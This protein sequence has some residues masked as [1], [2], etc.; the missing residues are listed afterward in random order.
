MSSSSSDSDVAPVRTSRKRVKNEEEWK[1]TVRKRKKVSGEAYTSKR[2]KLVERKRLGSPC[3]C[4]RTPK[5]FEKVGA[6]HVNTIFKNFYEL[7][8]HDQQTAYIVARV[9]AQDVKRCR[10]KD[11]PSKVLR[12]LK[13]TVVKDNEVIEVC[14]KAFLSMHAVGEKRVSYAVDNASSSGTSKPDQRGK[15]A[16]GI[17]TAEEKVELVRQNINSLQT[18][19]SHY[20]R[21]KSKDRKY[22][23]PGLNKQILYTMY[24]QW[25]VREGHRSDMAVSFWKFEDIFDKQFN[26]GFAPPKTDSCNTCDKL[27]IEIQACDPRS[28]DTRLRAL[29]VEKTVHK[30]KA[31]VAQKIL[32]EFK[33][34][35]SKLNNPATAVICMDLQQTLPTPKLTTGLQ[36]YKR[37]MWTYNFGVHNVKE[38]QGTMFVWNETQAHRGSCEVASCLDYYIDN[39]LNPNITKLVIFSDNCSGQNKN[40]NIILTCLRNIHAGRFTEIT[41]YFMTPGHSYLPCDRDFGI[42]EKK[43]RNINVYTTPHYVSLIKQTNKKHPFQVVEMT[44]FKS[45]DPLQSYASW[46]GM[47][48]ANFMQARVLLYSSDFKDGFQCCT[49]YSLLAPTRVCLKKKK[50]PFDLSGVQLADKYPGGVIPLSKEKVKDVRVL[51]TYVPAEHRVFFT[52]LLAA[53]ELLVASASKGCRGGGRVQDHSEVD[54]DFLDDDP[55]DPAN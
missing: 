7:A 21:A 24:K 41:H 17:K 16:P 28:D 52:N 35:K 46:A 48:T 8:D 45:Y 2:N 14:R 18:V 40:K 39:L 44:N 47:K 9:T 51:S 34:D 54:E 22:L 11:R 15:H 4:Y 43:I 13:Y 6:E 42:I 33:S 29:V 1:A 32:K 55:D 10:I 31:N 38:N 26:I 30:T 5:C 20:S 12:V 19:S 53:Q 3:K 27:D 49:H 25:L 23:P 36:Y 37:K 50:E